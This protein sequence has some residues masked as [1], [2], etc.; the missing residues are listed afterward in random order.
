MENKAFNQVYNDILSKVL[1]LSEDP[2]QFADYLTQ[3]IRELIGART[4]VIAV[5]A[6]SE[7]TKIFSV[8]PRRRT[9]WANQNEVLQLAELSGDFEKIQYLGQETSGEAIALLLKTLEIDKAIVIPLIAANRKVGSILLLDILDEFGIES[10]I[11]LLTRLSGVFALVIRN[12]ILYQNMENLV[13]TRTN[14]LRKK[15]NDLEEALVQAEKS[16]MRTRDILQ[17]AMDGFWVVD[18]KGKFIEVNEVACE[19]VGYTRKEMLKLGIFDLEIV[20]TAEQT[21]KHIQKIFEIGEDR[22]ETKHRCKNGEIIDVELSVKFQS[23]QNLFVCFVR[24]ITDRKKA[25]KELKESEFNLRKAQQM[26]HIGSWKWIMATDTVYWSEEL[27]RFHGLKPKPQAPGFTEQD[28]LATPESRERLK[29]A[30]DKSIQNG[31]SYEIELEHISPQDKNIK[32]TIARGEPVFDSYGKIIG[33]QGTLQDITDRKNA[34]KALRISEERFSLAMKASNDGLFDWNLE[35]NEIYYSPGWKKM[36]GYEDHEL[37]NDFSIWESHTE[38]GDA[39]RSWEMQ[40]KLILKQIDRFELEFKMKHKEGHWVDILSRAEAIFNNS[41]KAI[42]IVGTHVDITTQKM[43]EHDL[44]KGKSLLSEAEILT[45][46]GSWEWDIANEIAHWSDGLF[47]IFKRNPKEG[48]PNWKQ[49][50]AFYVEEDFIQYSKI[51]GECLKNGTPYEFELRAICSDGEIRYC[52]ARGRAERN[53]EQVIDRMWGTLQDITEQKLAEKKI[54]E[55]EAKFRAYIERAPVAVFVTNLEGQFL[56]INPAITN[57]LDYDVATLKKMSIQNIVSED[58]RDAIQQALENLRQSGYSEGEFQLK[59]IDGTSV[60][61][62]LNINLIEGSIALGYSTNITERRLAELALVKNKVRLQEAL[63]VSNRARQSLLSVL[64]DQR[65]AEREIQKL[66]AELEQRVIQ[67][68]AQLEEVNRE[69]ESFSYSVSHDLRAPLRHISGF[70]DMLA[71]DTNDQLSEKAQHY[72]HTINDS[73]RKMGVLID[74]LLSFSRTGRTEMRKTSIG[75]NQVVKDAIKQVEISTKDRNIEWEI[76]NLPA[77]YGDYNLLLLVWINLV[78]NAVKY[79]RKREKA[80]IQ[81]DCHKEKDEYIFR[82]CDNGA[83]FDMKY[84]QKLFG[85][86]QRLHSSNEFEGTGIGLANV[87]RIILR[88]GGRSWAEAEPDKGAT[89]YFTLPC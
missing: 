4:I 10:V 55:S 58:D 82:I 19:K 13:A 11:D 33:F 39:K 22:F 75:M 85:V 46:L 50:A 14:E 53:K 88:H 74:D 29:A 72:L 83:G 45:G 68:T 76:A 52:I 28:D 65:A 63:E 51:V 81:I 69:L 86:F 42:R 56:E 30:I 71:N 3:Q 6:E 25:E 24:D 34:E 41:G 7:P 38:P 1:Q 49:H 62:L 67:R 80:I 26:A 27:F 87:R 8:F 9:E 37:P 43:A 23:N 77:A 54:R 64:E 89:F 47:N 79:T 57:L 12:S 15:N 60:W 31:E 17:T 5:K 44:K 16:E 70:A 21:Q 78:D 40:Q 35:T 2:S 32:H 36:L 18:L 84:A 66:N 48:A 73:A 20:E 59:R 61:V